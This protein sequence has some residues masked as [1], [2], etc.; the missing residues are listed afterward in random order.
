MSEAKLSEEQLHHDLRPLF[1]GMSAPVTLK[2]VRKRLQ[3]QKQNLRLQR[4]ITMHGLEK[5]SSLTLRLME[6]GPL[7][8]EVCA[9]LKKN[10]LTSTNADAGAD[11]GART[12]SISQ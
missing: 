9:F 12:G 8:P 5:L 4:L 3:G 6:D 10:P 2:K 1:E 7:R 11:K